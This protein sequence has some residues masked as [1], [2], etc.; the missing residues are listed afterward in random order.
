M[1][2][3]SCFI[4]GNWT[5]KDIQNRTLGHSLETRINQPIHFDQGN[6]KCICYIYDVSSE[7]VS[8]THPVFIVEVLWFWY[9]VGNLCEWVIFITNTDT[10]MDLL[11]KQRM[12]TPFS[13]WDNDA[14]AGLIL[15]FPFSGIWQKKYFKTSQSLEVSFLIFMFKTSERTCFQEL[16]IQKLNVYF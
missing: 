7:S 11:S 13:F 15:G 2:T 3:Y 5:L 8:V 14:T 1:M 12:P 6:N 4:R 9:I 10:I 16:S